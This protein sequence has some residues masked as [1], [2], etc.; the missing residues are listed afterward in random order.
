MMC[1][2]VRPPDP[3]PAMRTL[4]STVLAALALAA[5]S[6]THSA[7]DDPAPLSDP[8]ALTGTWVVR[9]SPP[10]ENAG[11]TELAVER[12]ADGTFT[13]RFFGA[14][15]LDGRIESGWGGVH[16]SFATLDQG[17]RYQTY[18]VLADGRLRGAT[19]SP[20]PGFLAVWIA[21]RAD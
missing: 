19:S 8:S 21:E 12:V 15:V 17:T 4:L 11:S 16:F 7:L 20:E 18:G 6:L 13:G 3:E 1:G 14:E 2:L 9:R 10:P 5:C